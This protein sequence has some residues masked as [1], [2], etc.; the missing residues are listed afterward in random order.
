M[1]FVVLVAVV[2]EV[3]GMKLVV[4]PLLVVARDELVE[5]VVDAEVFVE[6]VPESDVIEDVED[7]KEELEINVVPLLFEVVEI[8]VVVKVALDLV[9][10]GKNEVLD[11]T[12]PVR[13]VPVSM[14]LLLI[15][16]VVVDSEE[17]REPNEVVEVETTVLLRPTVD[18]TLEVETEDTTTR[19]V[20]V[21]GE[22]DEVFGVV[23][24]STELEIKLK[25]VDVLTVER[26]TVDVVVEDG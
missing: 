16:N 7:R 9:E 12:R 10:V 1:Y 18:D 17:E 2:D 21:G 3:V 25:F 5:I 6:L 11:V 26:E 15:R 23:G 13:D 8:D 24:M 19:L 14:V 22:L 4:K 20:L